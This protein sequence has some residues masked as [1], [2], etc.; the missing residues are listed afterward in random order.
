MPKIKY[1]EHTGKE[2]DTEVQVGWSVMDAG[3]A[4]E[5]W[6][7]DW[8]AAMTLAA[9]SRLRPGSATAPPE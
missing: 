5:L 9:A 1:I 6:F 7:A 3:M 8:R 2:H 4:Y